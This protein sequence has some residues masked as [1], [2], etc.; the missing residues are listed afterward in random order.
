MRSKYMTVRVDEREGSMEK[1]VYARMYIM[2]CATT[3]TGNV[4]AVKVQM[5]K[6][7]ETAEGREETAYL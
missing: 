7:E 6:K 3:R 2:S 4:D 1:T 5:Q